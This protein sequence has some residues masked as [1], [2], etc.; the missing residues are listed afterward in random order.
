MFLL[1]GIQNRQVWFWLTQCGAG[2]QFEFV[3]AETEQKAGLSHG[4]VS[5]QDDSVGL[6]RCHVA[7]VSAA[8]LVLL[9]KSRETSSGSL[10]PCLCC[11]CRK[12]TANNHRM[13][14]KTEK[15]LS[16]LNSEGSER[17]LGSWDRGLGHIYWFSWFPLQDWAAVGA[18]CWFGILHLCWLGGGHRNQ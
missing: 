1:S 11:S 16:Y 12:T 6:L 13:K 10:S 9:L 2:V 3:L 7:Q 17:F 8:V 15:Y 5:R 18:E 14:Q 4:G